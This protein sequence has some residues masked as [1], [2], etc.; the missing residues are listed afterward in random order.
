MNLM[1][2]SPRTVIGRW[3]GALGLRGIARGLERMLRPARFAPADAATPPAVERALKLAD[4]DGL[5]DRGDYYEFGIYRGF[6]F[7]FAQAV[8]NRLGNR[9]MRFIGLDSFQ[10]LPEIRGVDR[11]K[12][13]FA[14][15][16]FNADIGYIRSILSRQGVD[17]NRTIL[18]PGYFESSLTASLKVEHDLRP[19]AVVLVDC[20]PY[21]SAKLVL[22]F[23]ADLLIDGSI[24]L[25]D[26]LNTFDSDDDR[27]ERRAL[28]E[29]LHAHP[30][31]S[32]SPLY[33]YGRYGQVFRM[34]IRS[35]A[36]NPQSEDVSGA[37]VVKS[38]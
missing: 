25:F 2:N 22:F 7:R 30:R 24:I 27:G 23:L 37:R 28:R 26:D 35:R 20:D 33:S 10:G 13:D 8:A 3:L 1:K 14:R 21:E 9:T 16:Q 29:F 36:P 15:G 17:W 4:A 11:Y 31:W 19:T 12:G 32:A 5:L 18:V 38:P 34:S 6:T